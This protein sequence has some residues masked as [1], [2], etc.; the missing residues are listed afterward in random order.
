MRPILVEGDVAAFRKHL[1]LWEELVGDSTE[2][3]AAPEDHTRRTMAAILKNP[4]QFGLPPWP[5]EAAPVT[6]ARS[7]GERSERSE[8]SPQSPEATYQLDMLTGELVPREPAPLTAA[9]PRVKRGR[10]RR[11]RLP[12]DLAQLALWSEEELAS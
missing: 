3:A 12:S 1:A 9:T 11:R 8:T 7:S 6:Y 10:P 2:L 4:R 5:R